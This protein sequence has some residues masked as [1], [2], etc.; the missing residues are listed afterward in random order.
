MLRDMLYAIALPR[1]EGSTRGKA[2]P[3][4]MQYLS[5][6]FPDPPSR[7]EW[8]TDRLTPRQEGRD[9]FCTVP[10]LAETAALLATEPAGRAGAKIEEVVE[11]AVEKHGVYDVLACL[12]EC[13][14]GQ[15]DSFF[16]VVRGDENETEISVYFAHAVSLLACYLAI[17]GDEDALPMIWGNKLYNIRVPV[18]AI[19]E[20]E[21][22][23]AAQTVQS[24]QQQRRDRHLAEVPANGGQLQGLPLRAAHVQVL[25]QQDNPC[26]T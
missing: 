23:L 16:H 1:V 10:L 17:C 11:D 7:S 4:V 2:W 5:S 18:S 24:G 12:A 26:R 20:D 14:A 13:F 22:L 25:Q 9:G 8:R 19:E 6:V 15:K 21:T 3:L